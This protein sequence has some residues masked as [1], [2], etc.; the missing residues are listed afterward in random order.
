METAQHSETDTQGDVEREIQMIQRERERKMLTDG[1]D[2]DQESKGIA[3][4]EWSRGVW[5]TEDGG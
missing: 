5:T 4:E 3:K 2:R 1:E